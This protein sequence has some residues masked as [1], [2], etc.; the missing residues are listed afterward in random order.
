[1]SYNI[2]LDSSGDVDFTGTMTASFFVGDGSQLTNLP[3][4]INGIDET[5]DYTWTGDH[6]FDGVVTFTDVF[7]A[8]DGSFAGTV[9]SN[10]FSGDGTGSVFI[11]QPSTGSPIWVKHG[12]AVSYAFYNTTL[13]PAGD[14]V[15]ELG[16]G[17]NRWEKT[18][19]VNGSFS[20]NLVSE[21]GGSYKLYNLGTE[22]DT[23]TEALVVSADGTTYDIFSTITGTGAHRRID[24]GG[25]IGTAFRGIRL[26]TTNGVIDWQYNNATK[27]R[28]DATTCK[29]SS[30]TTVINDLKPSA[31]DTHYNGTTS[32]RWS[33]VASV[34]GDFSGDITV[35]GD[36]YAP[37]GDTQLVLGVNAVEPIL[38]VRNNGTYTNGD[39]YGGANETYDCGTGTFRWA[40]VYSVAGNFSGTVTA[41]D[42]V[43]LN[44]GRYI[45]LGYSATKMSFATTSASLQVGTNTI[46]N[47]LS[48]Q[49]QF[50]KAIVP[51]NPSSAAC[52]LDA[53]RWSGVYSVDGSF[54]GNLVSEVGGSY[55]LYNLGTEGDAD[56]EYLEI[57]HDGTRFKID[58]RSTGT[59]TNQEV[60]IGRAGSMSMIHNGSGG[61]K[62]RSLVPQIN[63]TYVLGSTN[64]RY[65]N[66]VSVDGDFSG[67]VIARELSDLE[68]RDR[69]SFSS[70]ID[71]IVV[72]VGSNLCTIYNSTS[73]T[74]YFDFLPDPTAAPLLGKSGYEWSQ[75]WGVDGNFSGTVTTDSIDYDSSLIISNNGTERLELAPSRIRPSVNFFP[76]TDNFIVCGQEGS[77]WKSM[78]SVD[79]SFSGNLVSEVG[80]TQRL[81]NLGTE[82]DTD[83]E[84]GEM[85]W[86]SNRLI[87]GTQTT[88]AGVGRE[89]RLTAGLSRVDVKHNGNIQI[90]TSNSTRAI[91]G[92]ANITIYK[93]L[94][95]NAD[96]GVNFGSS[97]RR[98][99]IGYF[100]D[101]QTSTMTSEVGGALKLYSLG[102]EGDTDSE[103]LNIEFDDVDSAWKIDSNANIS[104]SGL[105]RQMW[106]D[107]SQFRIYESGTLL[108][109]G[110]S[111]E[112]R[113]YGNLVPS[114]DGNKSVGIASKRFGNYYG[115]NGD[116]S[117]D[118]VMAANVDFTG[119]PTTDP[120]TAGRLYNDSGTLKISSGG[121]PPP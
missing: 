102:A 72:R 77:R 120:N 40:N 64:L 57:S 100:G 116:F 96:L 58:A 99:N 114:T 110:E 49:V 39:L 92:N 63:D 27:F 85:Y 106:F 86:D 103:S 53:K 26:D 93:Y 11:E 24:I 104:G 25:F 87:L 76:K 67:T 29:I 33:N 38:V 23:D 108:W 8:V 83:T 51:N 2:P 17:N 54:S 32:L 117:G 43:I 98:W 10:F 18:W 35:G 91:F 12:T 16:L 115:V 59:G 97:T 13:R 41:N 45:G 73:V 36:I 80:G 22:G 82:G 3:S 74:N 44:S 48:T 118:V 75:I 111:N 14:G 21:A 52:G 4:A 119:L 95:P 9:T 79:G 112:M 28:V 50:Y 89:V 65:A 55:K 31:T 69:I 109:L 121:A 68:G 88:G 56:T 60:G 19:S 47:A 7:D 113:M 62:T 81:Y 105:P 5:G 107:A 1:M 46:F 20:G 78:A 42:G 84:F 61:T 90:A 34:D 30:T 37:S 6:T 66:V 70:G 101:V 15:I 71:Q 94:Q